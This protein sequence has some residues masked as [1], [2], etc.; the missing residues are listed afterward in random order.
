MLALVDEDHKELFKA[1]KFS[2]GDSSLQANTTEIEKMVRDLISNET[3]PMSDTEI[4]SQL[5]K[6]GYNVARRTVAKYRAME[7]ILPARYRLT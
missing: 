7:G 5:L 2:R 6:L 1:K 3:C 4:A